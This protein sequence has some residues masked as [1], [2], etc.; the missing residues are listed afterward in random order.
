MS[1]K[2]KMIS[3]TSLFIFLLI[4]SSSC[5]QWVEMNQLKK[6]TDVVVKE[7][8]LNSEESVKR[9]LIQLATEI[10]T[11]IVVLEKE[12]DKSM[13]NAAYT[14]QQVDSNQTLTKADLKN[15]AQQTGM[16]D[17]YLT[18]NQGDFTIVTDDSSMG[19]NL[20]S[21]AERHK[22]LLSGE[23][24]SIVEPLELK[25][26]TG[27]IF[28]FT[29]IP[30]LKEKGIVKIALN[31]NIIEDSLSQYIQEG[32]G[33]QSL[34]LTNQSGLVLTENLGEGQASRWKTGETVDDERIKNVIKTSKP[35]LDM[36]SSKA[37]IYYPIMVD[38][39]VRY[40][41]FAQIDTAPY[42]LNTNIASTSLKEVQQNLTSTNI[43]TLFLSIVISI[44]LIVVLIF[45][46]RRSFKPLEVITEHAQ[47]IALGD[48]AGKELIVKSKDEVGHL[49]SSFNIM[50]RNLREV[51][52]KVSTDAEHVAASAGELTASADQIS[53]ASKHISLT[54]QEVASGTNIQV[55]EVEKTDSTIA[56]ILRNVQQISANSQDAKEKANETLDKAAE[57][58]REIQTVVNQ[59]YII[60][61]TV[62][63]TSKLIEELGNYSTQIGQISKVIT[64]IAKQTNLLALNAAIEAAR[65]GEQGKG[66]MIVA[67]EVQNLAEKS[68]QSA[69]QISMLIS[70]IQEETVRAV[71]SMEQVTVEVDSGIGIVNQAGLT[72]G[73]IQ[74]AVDEVSSRISGVAISVEPL[75]IGMEQMA[76]VINLV[77]EVAEE[78]D[79]GT[80]NVSTATEQHLASIQGISIAAVSLTKMAEE[81]KL[82]INKFKM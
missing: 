82:L 39:E 35:I 22:N 38:N 47:R 18:D 53:N 1:L 65:A 40:V 32:D 15:L 59:M 9:K 37:E 46:I 29:A 50:V 43:S 7:L 64:E 57:G 16:T 44:V 73:A 36:E 58:N 55:K 72:F 69:N 24:S 33:V 61:E 80:Q 13:L 20:I 76:Q 10:T 25:I 27:E 8:H 70:R 14:L 30:R 81:L 79:S 2:M 17:L 77:R 19:L 63:E 51:I 48:L 56:D 71:T 5:L 28:K 41:L 21:L 68:S 78:T 45:V 6:Q 67:D 26:S 23:E 54:I 75:T 3:L 66:F 31:S 11:H 74:G 12:I 60:N 52:Q 34:Y 42:F 4:I 62:K 49:A